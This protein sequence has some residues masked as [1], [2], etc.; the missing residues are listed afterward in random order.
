MDE[1]NCNLKS[2]CVLLPTAPGHT[3]PAARELALLSGELCDRRQPCLSSLPGIQLPGDGG[4][5]PCSPFHWDHLAP[6]AYLQDL[7]ECQLK[8]ARERP[9]E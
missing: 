9:G 3:R 6:C 4:H 2:I 5:Q 1:S 7:G 8:Q